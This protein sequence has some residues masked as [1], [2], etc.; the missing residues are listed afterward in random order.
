MKNLIPEKLAIYGIFIILSLIVLFHLL[1][2]TG[3]IPFDIVWGGRLQN[4]SQMLQFETISILMNLVMLGIVAIRAG[5][6]KLNPN[7][8][9][10]RIALYLMS[11][12][13]FLNTIGNLLSNN[14]MEKIIFTP[15]TVILFVFS[16]RLAMGHTAK[17]KKIAYK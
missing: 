4:H 12:L 17:D 7:F 6:Y 1:I 11:G 14:H 3:V 16:L 5:F 10:V 15:L 2:V 9:I 13:F 8:P